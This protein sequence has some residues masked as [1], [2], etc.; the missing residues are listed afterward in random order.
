MLIEIDLISNLWLAPS[1]VTLVCKVGHVINSFESHVFICTGI[2][3]KTLSQYLH[4]TVT[5]RITE[6]K[7]KL[8]AN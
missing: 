7:V 4:F 5:Y 2:K 3:K 8:T 6:A 1:R